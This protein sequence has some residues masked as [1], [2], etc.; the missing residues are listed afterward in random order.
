MPEIDASQDQA[1]FDVDAMSR[2][3]G[4]GIEAEPETA[5]PQVEQAPVE[6][7]QE[8]PPVEAPGGESV[9]ATEEQT[10]E[11]PSEP[12]DN[13]ERSRLGREVKAL[14]A[15]MEQIAQQNQLLMNIIQAQMQ[16]A[17]PQ[18]EEEDFIPTSR[19]EMDAWL[20]Q[21]EQSKMQ[22]LSMAQQVYSRDYI[23]AIEALR[24]EDDDDELFAEASKLCLKRGEKFCNVV[25]GDGK[26]DAEV[27]LA[28]AKAYVLKSRLK[29]SKTSD[30]PKQNPFKGKAPIAPLG[31]GP[32]STSATPAKK[33]TK[34]NGD[35]S[36]LARD[37]GLNA[38]DLAKMGFEG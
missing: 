14:K 4:I 38:D 32:S 8:E 21:R 2:A 24:E 30:T 17:Q 13:A 20:E 22:R 29:G 23:G 5:A 19:K 9:E 3:A 11:A 18:Q 12:K 35:L 26:L 27:N 10:T 15:S 7:K 37:L 34:L 1:F 33:L 31:S 25:K 36:G 6:A 28:K 16:N